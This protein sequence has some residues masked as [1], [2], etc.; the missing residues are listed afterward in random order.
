MLVSLTRNVPGLRA[1]GPRRGVEMQR[2]RKVPA[3]RRAAGSCSRRS[4]A[5]RA[6]AARGER[7]GDPVPGRH[8]DHRLQR[9]LRAA[10]APSRRRR[11]ESTFSGDAKLSMTDGSYPPVA[12]SLEAE[13][14]KSGHLETR[15]LPTCPK[16]RLEATTPPQARSG[17]PRRDRRHRLRRR[18]RPLPRTGADRGELARSPSSTGPRSAATRP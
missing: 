4:V 15:G 14:D 7:R 9:R 17:V 18:R 13:F 11:A 12:T 5:W 8:A 16:G 3:V 10:G 6:L 2:S 1:L